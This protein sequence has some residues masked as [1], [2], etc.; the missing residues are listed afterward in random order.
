MGKT[1]PKTTKQLRRH[2]PWS[3][4][5]AVILP[6][7]GI[8]QIIRGQALAGALIILAGALIALANAT[9]PN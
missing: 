4:A 2:L 9:R 1:P 3:Y 8:A 7:A 6:M 5:A